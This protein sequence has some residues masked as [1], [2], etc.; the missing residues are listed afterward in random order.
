MLE[1]VKDKKGLLRTVILRIWALWM[2]YMEGLL[3]AGG[4]KKR[5]CDFQT[6]KTA[7]SL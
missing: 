5:E 3:S 1:E 2:L 7:T 4:L 6:V